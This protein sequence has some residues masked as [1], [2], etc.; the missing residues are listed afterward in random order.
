MTKKSNRAQCAGLIRTLSLVLVVFGV[1]GLLSCT[2]LMDYL[3]DF[4]R[5]NPGAKL[6]Q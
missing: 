5:R 1:I 3:T 6:R 4:K 2:E